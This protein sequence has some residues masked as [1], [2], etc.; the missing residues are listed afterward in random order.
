MPDRVTV[1]VDL[2]GGDHGPDVSLPAIRRALESQEGLRIV[3]VGDRASMAGLSEWP[4]ALRRRVEISVSATNIPDDMSPARALRQ[5]G[6]SSLAGALRALREGRA[7][8]AVSAGNTGALMAL[9][10]HLLGM[11]PGI[12]RPA[13]MARLPARNHTVWVLDLGANVGVDARRLYEFA[14]LGAAAVDAIQGRRPR[15]GLLNVGREASKGSDVVQEAARLIEAADLDYIGFVEGNDVFAGG[16]DVIVCDGFA[17]NVLLKGAEGI[18]ALLL[19]RIGEAL[20]DNF[21]ARFG[22]ALF[23][24]GLRRK[25][26]ELLPARHNGASLLGINGI[27][28]KSHGSAEAVAMARAIEL[29]ALEARRGVLPE[30][31]RRLWASY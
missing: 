9:A 10:R 3:A 15:V 30:I 8:A 2:M 6:D 18:A 7:G 13:L 14:L 31:E 26:A 19:D 28:I 29:A 22:S 27:V 12:E 24:R 11:L 17:G 23:G 20:R 4:E 16:A 1:A 21:S 25:L 5:G